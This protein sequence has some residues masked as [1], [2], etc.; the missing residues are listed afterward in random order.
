VDICGVSDHKGRIVDGQK[1]ERREEML[2][3]LN[4]AAEPMG[5]PAARL[6]PD[7][8]KRQQELADEVEK[9]KA[10]NRG[11]GLSRLSW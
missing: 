7:E 9:E 10:L 11:L 2:R 8:A 4:S 5:R 3:R 6:E 1:R